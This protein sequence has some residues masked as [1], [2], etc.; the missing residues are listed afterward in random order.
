LDKPSDGF[1]DS[2]HKKALDAESA[3]LLQAAF[4]NKRAIH[5]LKLAQKTN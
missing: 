4:V 2:D 1:Q 3:K 5:N